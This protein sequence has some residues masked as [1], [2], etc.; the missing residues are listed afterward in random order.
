MTK[1]VSRVSQMVCGVGIL[2]MAL[3]PLRADRTERAGT[4]STAATP[5][6]FPFGSLG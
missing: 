2:Q 4:R 6:F 3:R 1:L 5:S